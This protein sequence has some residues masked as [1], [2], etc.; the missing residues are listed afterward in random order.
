VR[1]LYKCRICGAERYGAFLDGLRIDEATWNGQDFFRIREHKQ[2]R[3]VTQRVANFLM[4]R[5]IRPLSLVPAEQYTWEKELSTP[6][7][8]YLDRRNRFRYNALT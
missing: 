5:R 3:I 8:Y 2:Y 6:E 4:E 1:L 7:D